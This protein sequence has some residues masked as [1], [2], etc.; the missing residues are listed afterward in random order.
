MNMDD[1]RLG[2]IGARAALQALASSP[3][4]AATSDTPSHSGYNTDIEVPQ[5]S[6]YALSSKHFNRPDKSLARKQM[7]Q[8]QHAKNKAQGY[9]K[10][11]T[12]NNKVK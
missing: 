12:K 11:L 6:P 9:G 8:A 3:D 1:H 5:T 4:F 7:R 10:R 2:L